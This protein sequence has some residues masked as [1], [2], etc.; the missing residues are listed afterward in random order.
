MIKKIITILLFVLIPTNSFSQTLDLPKEIIL[1]YN[2]PFGVPAILTFKHDQKSYSINTSI[3]I[4][5]KPMRFSTTG[6]ILNNK[7]LPITYKNFRNKK[8]YSE[9]S[10]NYSTNQVVLGKLPTR[11]TEK[12]PENTQDLFS[13][14]WQMTINHGLPHKGTYA[15][16]GKRLYAVPTL[17][18]AKTM[19][20]VLNGKK[21]Q[22]LIFKGGE[23]DRRLEIG[24][25]PKLHYIPAVIVYYDRG[26]RYELTLNKAIFK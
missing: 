21:Q 11:K 2:G 9:A 13:L 15:T 16:D 17:S 20:I 22:V 14:A 3:A 5:F 26:Q 12:F 24:L 1:E 19:N 7:L 8:L 23:G 6:G 4:P 10:F 25:A 18:Q